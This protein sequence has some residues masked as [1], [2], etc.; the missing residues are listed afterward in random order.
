MTD[1]KE[2]K[3]QWELV[4]VTFATCDECWDNNTCNVYR[5]A[6][7]CSCMKCTDIG[8]LYRIKNICGNC[9]GKWLKLRDMDNAE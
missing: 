2:F 4:E 8:M 9:M 5:K 6:W 3:T 7:G 1:W